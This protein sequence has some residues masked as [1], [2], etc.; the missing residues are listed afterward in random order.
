MK[1]RISCLLVAA[2]AA[3]A[4]AATPAGAT[5]AQ[6]T[7]LGNNVEGAALITNGPRAGQVAV[8]DGYDLRAIAV[9]GTAH[10]QPQTIFD[11]RAI[12]WAAYPS[13][14]AYLSPEKTF[15]FVDQGDHDVLVMTDVNGHQ[16]PTRAIT[17]LPD[18][19]TPIAS[20]EGVAYLNADATFPDTIARIVFDPDFLPYIEIL[21]RAGVVQRDIP[22]SGLPEFSYPAGLGYLATGEFLVGEAGRLW[23]VSSAGAVMGSATDVAGTGDLEAVVVAGGRIYAADYAG[24]TFLGFDKMLNRTPSRDR[25]FQIG[26]GLSR[27]YN[28]FWD[29]LTERWILL[30][31]DRDGVSN[32]VA[33]VSPGLDSLQVLF[34]SPG[35]SED[36]MNAGPGTAIAMCPATARRVDEYSRTGALIG[37][38]DLSTV[39][40]LPARG[41]R[42]LAYLSSLDAYAL[43]LRGGANVG[44]VFVVSRSGVLLSTI[45]VPIDV[46]ATVSASVDG[47]DRL[48]VWGFG[49]DTWTRATYDPATSSVLSTSTPDTGGVIFPYTYLAGPGDSYALL[50]PDDSEIGVF[51]G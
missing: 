10:T 34:H 44:K 19:P 40:G 26:I 50:N 8:I 31:I 45:T 32:D 7:R 28:G 46:V 16:L 23:H 13:G 20:A 2:A 15:A 6:Q 3:C 51:T 1:P 9:A 18:S 11:V 30:G 36:S 12:P 33:A 39:A 49:S 48:F 29:P 35:T 24:A 21:S 41:C 4:V 22:I 25:S 17:Y 43:V 14:M 38:L 42:S 47:P 5:A 27:S 37:G